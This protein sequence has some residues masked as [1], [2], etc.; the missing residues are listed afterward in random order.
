MFVRDMQQA[1][2]KI[3]RYS[4]GM[5]QQAFFENELVQDDALRNLTIIG[6]AAAKIPDDVRQQHSDVEWRKIIAFRNISMHEYFGLDHDIVWDVV[7][8]KVPELAV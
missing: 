3:R 7:S 2:E 8:R 5:D 6:E 1:C 4:A